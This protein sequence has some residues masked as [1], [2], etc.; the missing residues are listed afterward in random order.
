MG[1]AQVDFFPTVYDYMW[2]L[3]VWISGKLSLPEDIGKR[4]ENFLAGENSVEKPLLLSRGAD[5]VKKTPLF[6]SWAK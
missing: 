2:L 4:K 6:V 1:S 5:S 3:P